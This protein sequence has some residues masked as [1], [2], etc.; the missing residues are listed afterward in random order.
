MLPSVDIKQK[1][2]CLKRFSGAM[3]YSERDKLP[4]SKKVLENPS[5]KEEYRMGGISGENP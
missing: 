1:N 3:F 5:D 4:V 2:L